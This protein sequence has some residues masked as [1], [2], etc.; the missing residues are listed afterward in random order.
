MLQFTNGNSNNKVVPTNDNHLATLASIATQKNVSVAGSRS[1][2]YVVNR[3]QVRN[4]NNN[5]VPANGNHATQQMV[6][7][8][9][10]KGHVVNRDQVRNGKKR[11][12]DENEVLF[13]FCL[14]FV[15]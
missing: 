1:G 8:A 13:D 12:S 14:L 9:G 4:G 5:V 15:K 10:S 11:K 3:D 6:T 2:G 7:H